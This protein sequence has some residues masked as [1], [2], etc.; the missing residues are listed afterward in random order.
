MD[1]FES[2]DLN[3]AID[4]FEELSKYDRDEAVKILMRH[5]LGFCTLEDY[6]GVDMAEYDEAVDELYAETLRAEINSVLGDKATEAYATAPNLNF[7]LLVTYKFV[8]NG[9]EMADID[10]EFLDECIEK[11]YEECKK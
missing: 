1:Y 4:L 11:C 8:D 6:F 2:C 3:V 10:I 9:G 7:E 5:D